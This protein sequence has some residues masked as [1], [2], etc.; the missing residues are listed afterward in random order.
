MNLNSLFQVIPHSFSG[1]AHSDSEP[2]HVN[3]TCPLVFTWS[4][5]EM[6]VAKLHFTKEDCSFSSRGDSGEFLG[7][8]KTSLTET[9]GQHDPYD[10]S[11][12]LS[13]Y[14]SQHH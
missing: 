12:E 2:F 6:F 13:C 4:V 5:E 7:L 8:S 1:M 14:N 3:F 11:R 9:H 10:P